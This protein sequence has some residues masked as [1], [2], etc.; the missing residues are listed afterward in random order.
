MLAYCKTCKYRT[1]HERVSS[2]AYANYGYR[3]VTCWTVSTLKPT[4]YN[5]GKTGR[6]VYVPQRKNPRALSVRDAVKKDPELRKG[7]KLFTDFTGHAPTKLRRMK[8]KRSSNKL[9]AIGP[10]TAIMYLARDGRKLVHYIHRFRAGV[11]PSLSVSPDGQ[12]IELLGGAF[13]F[14]DRGIVDSKRRSR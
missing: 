1:K 10:V 7:A 13:R 3:C 8:V 4:D 5:L 9:V 11:R 14:T 2:Q 12:H 6:R